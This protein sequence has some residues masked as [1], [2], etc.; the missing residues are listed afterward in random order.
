MAHARLVA[1][2]RHRHGVNRLSV[3]DRDHP[4]WKLVVLQGHRDGTSAIV[5]KV[6]HC[7][8]DGV[9][10]VELTMVLHDLKRKEESPGAG[11]VPW[12]PRPL[13]DP[14]T[15][16]QDAVRDQLAEA[17]T[18]WTEDNFQLL[19]PVLAND[20]A[21]QVMNA[22]M[23]TMPTM[24][25]PAPRMPFN[26]PLSPERRFAWAEFSFSDIR[27]I[28]SALG[29]TINDVVLTVIAGGLGRYLR[30][31]G[32]RTDGKTIVGVIRSTF[33]VGPDGRLEQAQYGVKA[34]G[35]V[36]RLRQQLGV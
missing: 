14:L 15:M 28:R 19:R 10:G 17:A 20:R 16:M 8:V 18:N 35:H 6:H 21:R 34:T 2:K 31:R 33:V 36:A 25:Q 30:S 9:S 29:G 13:P 24:L 26:G 4:L 1:V 22:V 12:Q 5:W 32:Q 23:T 3:L 11:P 7:M 27:A